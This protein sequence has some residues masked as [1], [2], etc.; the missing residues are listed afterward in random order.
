LEFQKAGQDHPD[1]E[2][3]AFQ[4]SFDLPLLLWEFEHFLEYGI[5]DRFQKKIP[6]KERKWLMEAAT[7]LVDGIVK[8]P[9]GLT[10][11]DFQSRNLMLNEYRFFLIDFQDALMGPPAYDLVALL[12]DSYVVLPEE[13]VAL[14]IQD[15][16]DGRKKIG[17]PAFDR[18]EFNKQFQ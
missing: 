13:T 2:C 5:E 4:R 17:L 11:R 14:L 6:Q 7:L 12:R 8:I 9:Y 16:L 15:Y 1:P 3:M 10:H 18:E